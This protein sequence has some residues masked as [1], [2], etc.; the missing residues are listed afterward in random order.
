MEF[1]LVWDRV[2]SIDPILTK[3]SNNFIFMTISTLLL[4]LNK[5]ETKP[6]WERNRRFD[7]FKEV[8]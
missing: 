1:A 3:C 5:K 8:A 2:A 7:A 4:N 6:I